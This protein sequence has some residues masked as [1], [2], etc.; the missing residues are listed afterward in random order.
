MGSGL[1]VFGGGAGGHESSARLP[2]RILIDVMHRGYNG[3]VL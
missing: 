3:C 2:G 1:R